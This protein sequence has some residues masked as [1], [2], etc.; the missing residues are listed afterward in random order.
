MN[1]VNILFLLL[2]THLQA[3]LQ[4][5]IR[6]KV[7]KACLSEYFGGGGIFVLLNYFCF[8]LLAEHSRFVNKVFWVVYNFDFD[9]PLVHLTHFRFYSYSYAI[10]STTKFV[11]P[12]I[13]V[14]FKVYLIR[15]LYI[16]K[17]PSKYLDAMQM[18]FKGKEKKK[19]RDG[20]VSI[21]FDI[22]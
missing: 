15:A 11:K 2:A 22:L 14:S 9:F 10:T 1:V 21:L 6:L 16:H 5:L 8:L 20:C 13:F 19:L 12:A 3:Q 7:C 4:T 17:N 18:G